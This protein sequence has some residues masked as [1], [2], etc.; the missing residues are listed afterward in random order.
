MHGVLPDT[1]EAPMGWRNGTNV[2]IC[3]LWNIS[4]LFFLPKMDGH[5]FRA[6]AGVQL[7]VEPRELVADGFFA[8]V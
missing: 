4:L 8:A 3:T 2:P 6:V 7:F 1:V 5:G